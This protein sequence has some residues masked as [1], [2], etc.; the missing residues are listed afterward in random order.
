VPEQQNSTATA[1]LSTNS[2]C[3]KP[4][5]FIENVLNDE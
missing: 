3:I 5:Q 2:I 1:A 4:V